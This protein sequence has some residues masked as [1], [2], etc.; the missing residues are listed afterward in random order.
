[1][2]RSSKT[3]ELN[4]NRQIFRPLVFPL[5]SALAFYKPCDPAESMVV[6]LKKVFNSWCKA[7]YPMV[8]FSS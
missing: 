1:M 2:T 6:R 8:C 5:P 3:C 7:G 4:S